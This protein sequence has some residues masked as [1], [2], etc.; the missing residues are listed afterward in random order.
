MFGKRPQGVIEGHLVKNPKSQL[1]LVG[2]NLYDRNA[3]TYYLPAEGFIHSNELAELE[4]GNRS[5]PKVEEGFEDTIKQLLGMKSK[6]A[7]LPKLSHIIGE[8]RSAFIQKTKLDNFL[9]LEGRDA[10]VQPKPFQHHPM[11]F[12]SYASAKLDPNNF[13]MW[14]EGEAF[15]SDGIM[16]AFRE[17][18]LD[19]RYLEY[20]WAA[21]RSYFDILQDNGLDTEVTP[22]Y[23]L[24]L[25]LCR[26][27][28]NINKFRY[29]HRLYPNSRKNYAEHIRKSD[30]KIT[31]WTAKLADLCYIQKYKLNKNAPTK[32]VH[33][34]KIKAAAKIAIEFD[35]LS[36]EHD[37][38]FFPSKCKPEH[39]AIAYKFFVNRAEKI[40]ELVA[41]I[42]S[43]SSVSCVLSGET[44]DKS[45]DILKTSQHKCLG[46]RAPESMDE[47]A[48]SKEILKKLKL[49]DL[50]VAA[51]EYKLQQFK[52]SDVVKQ[53]PS[54]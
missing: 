29:L 8:Y 13:T 26:E 35:P 39:L 41:K 10:L 12:V 42:Q 30:E 37:D 21:K 22:I 28:V 3:K 7:Y 54:S 48:G 50:R 36:L 5:C 40:R 15:V 16:K 19:M 24:Y 43:G 25:R 32:S 46:K 1:S 45:S 33:V 2:K 6:P 49:D 18:P 47:D 23:N 17:K 27:A 9:A 11:V 53:P 4:M 31:T 52:I 20:A 38:D 44:A 14:K 34:S 51:Q